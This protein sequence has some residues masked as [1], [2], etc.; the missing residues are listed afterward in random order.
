VS[1]SGRLYSQ[2]TLRLAAQADPAQIFRIDLI[3]INASGSEAITAKQ[4]DS[5]RSADGRTSM[6]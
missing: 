5:R 3:E 1:S 6:I 4:Y 2:A